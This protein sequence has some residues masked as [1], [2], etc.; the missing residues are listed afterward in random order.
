[1][2]S[3]IGLDVK[4]EEVH[5]LYMHIIYYYAREQNSSANK[6]IALLAMWFLVTVGD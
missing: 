2:F 1:M 6:E 3:N 5:R 4:R